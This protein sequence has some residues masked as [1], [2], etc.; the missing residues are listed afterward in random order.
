M[1][2]LDVTSVND[3]TTRMVTRLRS[4]PTLPLVLPNCQRFRNSVSYCGPQMWDSLTPSTRQIKDLD[5]FKKLIRTKILIE[6]ND[7]Q[8]V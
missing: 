5:E 1:S 2:T 8:W 7:L 4:A 6:F 3:G